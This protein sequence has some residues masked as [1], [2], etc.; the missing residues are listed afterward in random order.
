MIWARVAGI[1]LDAVHCGCGARRGTAASGEGSTRRVVV[2]RSVA[3]AGGRMLAQPKLCVRSRAC[4]D[5]RERTGQPAV[6]LDA[7]GQGRDA[8]P[9]LSPV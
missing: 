7:R 1:R 3:G 2:D 4:S 9:V 8:V 6:G 5:G